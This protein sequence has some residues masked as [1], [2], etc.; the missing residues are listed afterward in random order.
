MTQTRAGAR[1]EWPEDGKI[2]YFRRHL[3][4][5]GLQRPAIRRRRAWVRVSF[6]QTDNF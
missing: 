3:V 1:R 5:F 4:D 6:T 2:L